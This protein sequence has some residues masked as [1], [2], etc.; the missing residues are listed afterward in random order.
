MKLFWNTKDKESIPTRT[1]PETVAVSQSKK[2]GR[3]QVR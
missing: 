1:T 3:V 2:L